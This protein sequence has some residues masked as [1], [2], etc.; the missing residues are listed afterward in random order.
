V[1]GHSEILDR[2]HWDVQYRKDDLPWE[3][4]RPS[5]E[6]KRVLSEHDVQPCRALE[7]G[8]GTGAN[9]VWLAGLGFDVTAVDLSSI[10]L[11][12]AR[13][14]AA[15]AGVALRFVAADLTRPGVLA[16]PFDFFFDN[17]CYHAVRLADRE[18]YFRALRRVT[19][20]GSLGLILTGNARE[21]EDEDGP[22]VLHEAELRREW[23]G[24]FEIVQLRPFRLDA[25]RPGARRY[26]GWS[27]LVQRRG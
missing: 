10:A 16:G 21:P 2:Q 26:L 6:L 5:T 15:E 7:L 24:P 14:R 8:C 23:S 20:P 12:K 19:R 18:G 13:D 3:T 27:C 1:T 9:A 11:H 4:D 17:G 25:P 22:P